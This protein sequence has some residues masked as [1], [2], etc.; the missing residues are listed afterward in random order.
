MLVTQKCSAKY[1]RLNYISDRGIS[2]SHCILESKS[3]RA[4]SRKE[5][6]RTGG[7]T[8]NGWYTKLY[9]GQATGR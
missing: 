1:E 4:G 5:G 8:S 2:P 3:V 6:V 7:A 9:T